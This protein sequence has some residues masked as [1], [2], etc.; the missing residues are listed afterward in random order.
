MDAMQRIHDELA[1]Y[2]V[3]YL[4]TVDGD[5]P[6]VRPIG[7]HEM[8]E[9]KEWFGVGTFKS[10]YRQLQANPHLQIVAC[11]GPKWIRISGDAEFA[12]DPKVAEYCLDQNPELKK[13]YNEETG[14]K[15]GCFTL[16]NGHVELVPM[17][18]GAQEE[19]DFK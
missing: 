5:K 8:Y 12:E 17:V 14:N 19:F 15:M 7:M 6:V 16:K 4:A 18:M 3:F 9:G 2:D 1:G 10:V 13:I 11:K